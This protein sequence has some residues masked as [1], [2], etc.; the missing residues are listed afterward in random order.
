MAQLLNIRPGQVLR[1]RT[2]TR[3]D[4]NQLSNVQ[5]EYSSQSWICY[6]FFGV[7]VVVVVVQD[8]VSSVWPWLF[9]NSRDLPASAFQVLGL[10]VCGAITARWI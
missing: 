3:V 9:W 4:T 7:V 2:V 6:F 5:L 1:C 8:R 10:K